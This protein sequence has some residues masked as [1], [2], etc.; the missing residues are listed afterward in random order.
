MWQVY[1]VKVIILTRGG[2][3]SRWKQRKKPV[4]TTNGEK[5]AE[6][7]VAQRLQTL[8]EGPNSRRLAVNESYWTRGRRQKTS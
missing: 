6:A 4:V 3:T 1:E 7:I 8:R 5:S 2:L